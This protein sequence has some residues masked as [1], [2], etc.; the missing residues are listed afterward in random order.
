MTNVKIKCTSVT[1]NH[2]E[3]KETTTD[4]QEDQTTQRFQETGTGQ[5]P[6]EVKD[7][8]THWSK[9]TACLAG[10]KNRRGMSDVQNYKHKNRAKLEKVNNET[11]C[12]IK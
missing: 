10:S 11:S 8:R 3:M 12:T 4:S 5:A 2:T 1:K 6:Q 9:S 7:R